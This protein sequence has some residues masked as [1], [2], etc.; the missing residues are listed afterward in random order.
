MK[1]YI[2]FLAIIM[3]VFSGCDEK[4][5]AEQTNNGVDGADGVVLTP[6]NNAIDAAEVK[7]EGPLP[8]FQFEEEEHD[9]G[10][11]TEGEV[12]S[13]TFKFKNVGDAP[14]VIQN[15]SASC[16]C[17]QP[18]W[19]KDPIAAGSTGEIKVGFNSAGRTGMQPKT[20]TIT[21]NTYPSIKKINIKSMVEAKNNST[22]GP[23]RTN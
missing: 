16:G 1:T 13:H 8:A 15:V 12:V 5:P 21:A 14:L 19:T 17:T 11:I 3:A 23:V 4:K 10:T 7:P 20:I 22:E 6:S 9:F 2:V 18:E